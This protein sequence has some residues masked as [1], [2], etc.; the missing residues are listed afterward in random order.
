MAGVTIAGPRD[1]PAA[2]GDGKRWRPEVVEE[3]IGA[4]IEVPEGIL[5]FPRAVDVP[6]TEPLQMYSWS[7]DRVDSSDNTDTTD[8]GGTMGM[9][10]IFESR[11]WHSW[12]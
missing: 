3:S 8:Y 1:S 4:A 11:P 5:R 6:S 12:V 7:E 10:S 2:A 9:S